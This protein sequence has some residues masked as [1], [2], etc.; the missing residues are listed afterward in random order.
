MIFNPLEEYE[1]KLK[2]V[3]S[4]NANVF[5]ENLVKQSGVNIEENRKTVE[6]Y[7][8]EKILPS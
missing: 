7:N 1:K 4:N 8:I 3:H 2:D 6:Q 5:F